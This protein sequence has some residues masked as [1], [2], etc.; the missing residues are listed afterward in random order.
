V[1]TSS[2][3]RELDPWPRTEVLNIESMPVSRSMTGRRRS[4]LVPG[5][6]CAWWTGFM[7]QVVG[8]VCLNSAQFSICLH[9]LLKEST[10][11]V[12]KN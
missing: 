12:T 11:K 2:N 9:S 4:N 8:I 6:V 1:K 5:R 10:R 3:R 7:G